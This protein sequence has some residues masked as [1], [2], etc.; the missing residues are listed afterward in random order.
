MPKSQ[1]SLGMYDKSTNTTSSTNIT[2][3]TSSTPMVQSNVSG[4]IISQVQQVQHRYKSNKSK[5]P[6]RSDPDLKLATVPPAS[7]HPGAHSMPHPINS[8]NR[9]R[10][11]ITFPSQYLLYAHASK[12]NHT[13]VCLQVPEE[14]K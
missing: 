9:R 11:K 13:Q 2:N 10:Y 4:H 14:D 7:A 1:I 3:T 8:A 6:H 5:Y 12:K